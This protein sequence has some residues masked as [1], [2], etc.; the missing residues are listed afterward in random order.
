MATFIPLVMGTGGVASSVAANSFDDSGNFR[1]RSNSSLKRRRRDA[2]GSEGDNQQ[3][4]FDIIRD[5]PPLVY[6]TAP[7][8]D[9][10]AIKACMVEGAKS[11]TE[12]KGMAADK[13]TSNPNKTLALSLVTLYTL[14]ESVVEKAIFPLS[15]AG[16]VPPAQP[17]LIATAS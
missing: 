2:W 12:I 14:L 13:K 4:S 15:D 16:K 1:D 5:Y 3:A 9:V 10:T 7:K 6:P 11:V 17:N 8:L